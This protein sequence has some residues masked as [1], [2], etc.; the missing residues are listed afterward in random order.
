M[1]K[2][3]ELCVCVS[4][5]IYDETWAIFKKNKIP[6]A[7]MR[8]KRIK[9]AFLGIFAAKVKIRVQTLVPFTRVDPLTICWVYVLRY[10]LRLKNLS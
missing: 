6:C 5:Y 3:P 1:V 8:L 9:R 7:L 4:I 2:F 10:G